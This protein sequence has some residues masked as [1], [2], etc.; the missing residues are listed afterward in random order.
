MALKDVLVKQQ[1]AKPKNW[2]E[3]ISEELDKEDFEWLLACLKNHKDFSGTHIANKLT[4]AG[5]PVSPTTINK[6]RQRI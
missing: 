6:I 3:S 4:E 5:H 2:L 1:K